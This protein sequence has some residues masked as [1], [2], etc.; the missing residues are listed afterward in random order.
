[1][2]N[3]KKILIIA[4]GF[5]IVALAFLTVVSTGKKTVNP[6]PLLGEVGTSSSD[7]SFRSVAAPM[8]AGGGAMMEKSVASSV[9]PMMADQGVV[10]TDKKVIKNGNLDLKIININS[11]SSEI[12]QIAKDNGGDVFSTNFYQVAQNIKQGNITVKIPVANFEKAMAALKKVA[13]LVT[14]ESTSG[15]DVTEQYADLQIQLANKQAEEQQYLQILKQAQKVSDILEITQALSNV[16]GEIESIQGQIKFLSSQTDMAS[17]NISLTEDQNITFSDTWRPWQVVKE[18]F[19]SLFKDLQGTVNL[20]IVIIIRV[21]PVAIIYALIAWLFYW[22]G[23]K[24]YTKVK[25]K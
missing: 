18:T 16:R 20:I 19:N 3:P 14:Q 13:T 6:I 2:G 12:S 5:L 23:K 4:I 9:A 25:S 22:G 8:A 7:Q 11:A 17:I 21:I 10:V 15:A 24:I 1:M